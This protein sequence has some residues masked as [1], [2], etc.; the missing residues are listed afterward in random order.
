MLLPGWCHP[1]EVCAHGPDDPLAE[2]DEPHGYAKPAIEGYEY[3]RLHLV[4]LY[5][6]ILNQT[7]YIDVGNVCSKDSTVCGTSYLLLKK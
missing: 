1:G 4:P 2:H 7:C 6:S 5:Y 3:R